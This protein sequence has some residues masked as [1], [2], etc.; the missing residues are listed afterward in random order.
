MS[1]TEEQIDNL[2]KM[3][4]RK[5][6]KLNSQSKR[7]RRSERNISNAPPRNNM[8]IKMQ[9]GIKK[10]NERINKEN[11][12]WEE[13]RKKWK[14]KQEVEGAK[15]MEAYKKF[16]SLV[17]PIA[18]DL[19]QRRTEIWDTHLLI[20]MSCKNK[21]ERKIRNLAWNDWKKNNK[22]L[23]NPQ[24]DEELAYSIMAKEIRQKFFEQRY[25]KSY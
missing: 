19:K 8:K 3:L 21:D 17:N 20:Y 1:L 23:F 16:K 11:S 22:A 7:K 12:E 24:S 2:D 13:E 4:I 9:E 14:A 18:D 25:K 6:R 15:W 5:K 10:R